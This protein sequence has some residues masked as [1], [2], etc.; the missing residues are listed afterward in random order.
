[1]EAS[2]RPILTSPISAMEKLAKLVSAIIP[3]GA[4]LH[5]SV[6]EPLHREA[7]EVIE[8]HKNF[9][10][11]FKRLCRELKAEG[12]VASDIPN[13]WLVASLDMMIFTAWEKIQSGDLAANDAPG[14]VLRTFL[15][16]VGTVTKSPNVE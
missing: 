5:F 2:V 11:W 13:T 9:L 15:R 16:G 4:S 8:G 12:I 1:M 10:C 14:L 6:Y 7:P 3:M